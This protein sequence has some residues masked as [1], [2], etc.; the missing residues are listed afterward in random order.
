[1]PAA[2]VLTMGTFDLF[3]AGHVALLRECRKLAGPVGQV[4]AAVNTDSFV[5]AFKD[6]SPVIPCQQ[7]A[8]VVAACRHVDEVIENTGDD[9][10]ALI[11]SVAPTWLVVG[12]DWARRDYYAQLG[13]TPDWL[14]EHGISLVYIGHEHSAT[15]SSSRIRQEISR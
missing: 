5:E 1:M 6:R 4:V 10:A 13:V 15:V 2:T 8:A 11:A 14:T 12:A 9:Q 3:H 7:R